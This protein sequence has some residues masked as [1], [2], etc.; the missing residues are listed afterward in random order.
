MYDFKNI[1]K[2]VLDYWKKNKTYE[3]L[4][5]INSKGKKFYFLQG[6]PYT[7]GRIHLGQAWNYSLKDQILRYKRMQGFDVW[8]RD[9][10]DMHGLPTENAVQ[11]QLKINDK[12]E[13]ENYGVDKFVK[14]CKNFA[15]TMMQ[16]MVKNFKDLGVWLDFNNAYMPIKNEFMEG[17]WALIKKAYDNKRLYLGEKVMTWCAS[18]ETSLA[19]HELE[20]KNVNDKS[21]FIKFKIKNSK[22]EYLII[23]TT[24]PWTIAFNLGIMVN[25]KL[26]YVKAKVGNET[27]VLAK[28]L[29]APVIQHFTDSKLEII[30]EFKGDKLKGT[31]YE[32]PFYDAL[33]HKYDELKSPNIFT[34]VLSEQYVD[35]SAGTGLVHM[36]PGCGPEDYEVGR[37]NNIHPFNNLDEKG[38]YAKDMGEFS[39]LNAKKDNH[40]FIEALEKRNVLIATTNVDHDYPHCWR[41]RNPVIFK[42]TKQ[43][44]FKI[45]DLVPKMLKDSKKVNWV[46]KNYEAIYQSWI[47]NLKDNGITRQ[48]YWGTPMPLW[49]CKSC[50]EKIIIGSIKELQKYA[51]EIPKDI[52]RPW[53]DN[54]TFKCKKCSGTME[55]SPD[56][57]DVWLDSG[58]A[59][60]NSLYNNPKLIKKYF[61]AD[62]I[63]EATEQTRLWFY[64]LQLVSTIMYN[65]NCYENVYMHGMVRDIEGVKMSKSIGNI[66]PPQEILDKY[67]ADTFRFYFSSLNA[68]KDV[69]FSW[70]EIKIKYRNLDVLLNTS[71][72]LLNYSNNKL[73]PSTLKIE[74]K[75]IL[76]RLNSTIKKAT[77]LMDNY[78]LDEINPLIENLFLDLSRNYIQ[79][80][81]DRI[82]EKVVIQTIKNVLLE[83]I[84][85]L[86]II[87]PF[88]TEHIYQQFK[89]KE[90][91]HLEKWPKFNTKLINKKLEEDIENSKLIIQ[92]IL[93]ER[94][95]EKMNV[96]WPLSEVIITTEK[97]I[98]QIIPVI[99]KQTNIK[100]I[101]LKK[102]KENI[103]LNTKLTPE[104]EK[105]GFTREVL[106]RI[107]AL[108]K[109]AK[110]N[111]EDKIELNIKSSIDLDYNSIKKATNASIKEIK[112]EFLDKFQIKEEEFEISFN[113]K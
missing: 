11:K 71:K 49:Q 65:Q 34:V 107:Q 9:G 90:S 74:D 112:G 15:E 4:K 82:E 76:S 50:K 2:E 29:A 95:K 52:H 108:R 13:I 64:M 89:L 83:T 69:N 47:S 36:A 40:K 111:K 10:Y 35:T 22:N 101:T 87:S 110:L 51:K 66:I 20:Y 46:P 81:R 88:I 60:F 18:C 39:G 94:E 42:T 78:K 70:E 31:K 98:Q 54:I 5:K 53:I 57:L 1:E 56:V 45:E 100:K 32:H 26:D 3:K 96:R 92:N 63:L 28:Q 75:W 8:D 104:L 91:I 72:Y 23:W 67:G 93:A 43:W 105:E 61:P 62:L 68:G 58:T 7:S 59:S 44:F 84:K 99:Q 55:R 12:K 19:K 37:E 86:S 33:K 77:E 25:P 103:K 109:K 16:N 113:T 24:T 30:E 14:E 21:I 73:K 17:E 6:P 41:C 38:N 79:L 48:R 85:M 80:V 106:R 27:W 102:G 97:S